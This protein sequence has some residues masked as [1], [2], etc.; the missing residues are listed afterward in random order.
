MGQIQ[1][2]YVCGESGLL[3]NTWIYVDSKADQGPPLIGQCPFCYRFICS[4]HGEKLD[5]SRGGRKSGS[6]SGHRKLT[7]LVVCCP[8]DPGI[9]L[10]ENS[11][12]YRWRPDENQPIASEQSRHILSESS[13]GKE[14]AKARVKMPTG[15]I[16]VQPAVDSFNVVSLSKSD[17]QHIL[18]LESKLRGKIIG[19]DEAIVKI[20]RVIK[21]AGAGLSDSHRPFGVFLFAGSRGVDKTELAIALSEALFD[22]EEAVLRLNMSKF[23]EENQVSYLIGASPE[24]GGNDDEGQLTGHLRQQPYSLVLINEMEKAH[25]KVQELLLQLFDNGYLTDAQGRLV[26]GRNAIFIMTTNLETG[27]ALGLADRVAT[28]QERLDAAIHQYFSTE[29]VNRIDQIIYFMPSIET[30]RLSQH[31]LSQHTSL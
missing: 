7:P 2:C 21:R 13:S 24:Y 3:I 26:N 29:F 23:T 1:Q 20:A 12:E 17:K 28:Y 19:Q 6:F 10:G 4:H 30:G 11:A 18:E 14:L 25:S 5:L 8:F 16:P 15:E 9:P 27:E 31:K 22:R